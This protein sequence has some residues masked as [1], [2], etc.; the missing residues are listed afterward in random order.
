MDLTQ[1]RDDVK[2]EVDGSILTLEIPDETVDKLIYRSLRE[3]NRYYDSFKTITVPYSS[4]IDLSAYKVNSVL[5]V[6]RAQAISTDI[7][8]GRTFDPLLATQWQLLSG[9]GNMN[10]FRDFASNYGA[11][12][13]LL[14]IR[15]TTSTDMSKFFDKD[16]QKLYINVSSNTPASVTI[17]F[18]P[19]LMNVEQVTSEYWQDILLRLSIA[20]VK[21]VLGRVRSR[22]KQPNALWEQDGDTMLNEGNQELADLRTSLQANSYLNIAID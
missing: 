20:H 9:Y 12:N 18:V 15:N 1:L 17:I 10:Q 14:Q 8:G 11:W 3:L 22:F 16:S 21:I 6:L 2:T 13:T 5:R 19:V 4:C 7:Q